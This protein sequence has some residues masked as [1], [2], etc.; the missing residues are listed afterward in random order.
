LAPRSG[1]RNHL[2]H[3]KRPVRLLDGGT[4]FEAFSALSA[5]IHHC[6]SVELIDSFDV[7][8][9]TFLFRHLRADEVLSHCCVHTHQSAKRIP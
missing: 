5:T 8:I 4:D 3:R 6:R 1:V 9:M 7:V 2:K